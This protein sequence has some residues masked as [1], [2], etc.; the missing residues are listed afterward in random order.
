MLFNKICSSTN[1]IQ[2]IFRLD[3]IQTISSL[4]CFEIYPFLLNKS[5]VCHKMFVNIMRFLLVLST[6]NNQQSVEEVNEM[7]NELN[8]INLHNLS[9]LLDW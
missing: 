7:I 8:K 6:T 5:F 4:Q 9:H 2:V 1:G 3:P